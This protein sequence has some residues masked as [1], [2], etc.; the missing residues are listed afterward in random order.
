MKHLLEVLECPFTQTLSDPGKM[1]I[2]EQV[3]IISWLED[4][5]IREM[6]IAA[7]DTIRPT[8]PQAPRNIDGY[9]K[10]IGCPFAWYADSPARNLDALYWALSQGVSLKYEDEASSMDAEDPLHQDQV[11]IDVSAKMNDL[12]AQLGLARNLRESNSGTQSFRPT[13]S[14]PPSCSRVCPELF[15]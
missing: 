4:R 8:N 14:F 3:L 9:L 11:N 2:K 7:R 13:F 10:S 5:V 15:S 1:P 6:E 12:G